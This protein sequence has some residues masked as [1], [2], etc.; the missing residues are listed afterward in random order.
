MQEQSLKKQSTSGSD[1]MTGLVGVSQCLELVFPEPSSRPCRRI[2]DEWR[3]KGFLPCRKIGRR[4]FMD[5]TEV[6]RAIDRQF[7]IE[8]RTY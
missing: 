5:P 8:T 3:A 7:K 1:A 6:R 2:W 4:V